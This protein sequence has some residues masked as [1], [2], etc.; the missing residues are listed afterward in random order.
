MTNQSCYI[1]S[2]CVF[3]QP[4]QPGVNLSEYI[5][6]ENDNEAVAAATEGAVT[7]SLD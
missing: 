5:L 3:S 2:V 1:L 7:F 6:N 4:S